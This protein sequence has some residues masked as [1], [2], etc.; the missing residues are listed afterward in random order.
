MLDTILD[1]TSSEA[2]AFFL[3]E[4]SYCNFSLPL[5]FN[6]QPLLN[7]LSNSNEIPKCLPKDKNGNVYTSRFK[8][9]EQEA[10][11]YLLYTNKD[12]KL[13]W[14]PLEL[15]NPAAYVYLVNIITEKNSWNQIQHRF[16]EFQKNSRIRCC[17]I[18]IIKN[19][20]PDRCE[21]IKGW[22]E[23]F[24]RESIKLSLDY[25]CLLITDITNCYGSIYTHSV[26]WALHS[27][28]ERGAKRDY[29]LKNLLCNAVD[30]VI[31]DISYGQTNGIPQGSILMDFI[32]EIVLGY[33]DSL[34]S[35]AIKNDGSL[36]GR[37][38]YILR[39][40]DDYRV[41][42]QNKTDAEKIA[43]HLSEA[44]ARLN[45]KLNES[46]T[47]ITDNIITDAQKSDKLY[48]RDTFEC[49]NLDVRILQIHSL[50]EKYP[51][52]GSI[53]KALMRFSDDMEKGVLICNDLI[54]IASV[55]TDI[56]FKN[57]RTYPYVVSILGKIDSLLTKQESEQ[58]FEKIINK[59]SLIP[60]SEYLYIW[61]QRLSKSA[62]LKHLE[63][64]SPLCKYAQAICKKCPKNHTD[65]IWDY[66]ACGEEVRDIFK[67]TPFVD[68]ALFKS[69]T[70]YPLPEEIK[71]F[72]RY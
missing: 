32:A 30:T 47:K 11:N 26:A 64:D 68:V 50:A 16:K 25:N 63:F 5:Y 36:N 33:A 21:T 38:Y 41:F 46:K 54:H 49:E 62:Q 31:R 43:R 61:L 22:F 70:N 18:P 42:T 14:R 59:F 19:D 6:F 1:L 60:N 48:W 53:D 15:I 69:M 66:S 27:D 56:A 39:Y 7:K 44:L 2:R 12:G 57:P 10:V 45:L 20:L 71:I 23:S 51:N 17:S 3:A 4:N 40:R 9:L 8:P 52:S 55:V 28:G 58:L 72:R 35:T 67:N 65:K 24:E 13:A 34:L 29:K 37:Q